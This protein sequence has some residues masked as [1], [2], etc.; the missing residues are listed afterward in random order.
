[1]NMPKFCSAPNCRNSSSSSSSDRRSFYKFPLQ[2][3]A[4]LQQW[5]RNMGREDWTPSR[6]QYICHEHFIPSCFKVRWGVRYLESNAVP[7]LFHWNQKRKASAEDESNP[8]RLHL[9]PGVSEC[10]RAENHSLVYEVAV[11]TSHQTEAAPDSSASCDQTRLS[12]QGG[13]NCVSPQL[14]PGDGTA[15]GTLLCVDELSAQD[16]LVLAYV[17]TIPSVLPCEASLLF[18]YSPDVVLCSA[19]SPEPISSTLPIVSKHQQA[20]VPEEDKRPEEP[21]LNPLLEEHCYHK[22]SLEPRESAVLQLQ[23]K[24]KLLQRRHRRHV[25]K[26]LRLET[27]LNQ[28]MERA[29]GRSSAGAPDCSET[30]TIVYQG[31]A[32]PYLLAPLM[33]TD[34]VTN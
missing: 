21:E 12:R 28:L 7:T 23:R 14:T 6:H 22:L 19:L 26:L 4:R 30:V 15:V 17:E 34:Q 10:D 31:D 5:L 8:K 18:P 1:M 25:T 9:S 3:Q 24:V 13:S 16:D 11:E 20:K 32:A 33:D 2:D 27:T 29:Y